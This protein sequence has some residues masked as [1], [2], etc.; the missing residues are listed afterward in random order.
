[1]EPHWEPLGK[2]LKVLVNNHHRF[3]TD[4]LLLADFSMPRPGQHCADLG[5]GCGT[6][7]LLWCGRSTPGLI[8]AVELQADAAALAE[9]SVRANALEARISLIQGDLRDYKALLPH[10]GLDLAA[11]NPPYFPPQ[12]GLRGEIPQRALA[13]HGEDFSLEDLALAARYSL[14]CGGRL[15]LCLPS[16][17]LA[18]AAALFR[19]HGLEPKRLRLVQSQTE[20]SPYLFLMECRSG[21]KPGLQVEPVLILREKTG[22]FTPEMKQIYGDYGNQS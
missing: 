5:C 8:Y 14:K 12:S 3:N 2:G 21:G 15:C 9:R 17:R 6:I 18:E 11:C 7:S 1:M 20:K 10:Q 16:F 4:T 13:R 22:E 19:A